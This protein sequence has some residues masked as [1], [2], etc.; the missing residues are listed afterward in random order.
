MVFVV[1]IK[2][3]KQHFTDV[4]NNELV[5]V[6]LHMPALGDGRSTKLKTTKGTLTAS[7]LS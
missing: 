7:V 1:E 2:E 6:S 3:P 4:S 5:K